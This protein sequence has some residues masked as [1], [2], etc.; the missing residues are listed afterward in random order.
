MYIRKPLLQPKLQLEMNYYAKIRRRTYF[1]DHT[2]VRTL[3]NKPEK[4]HEG[5]ELVKVMLD[6]A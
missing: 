2:G 1:N 4:A 3:K 5:F 6:A